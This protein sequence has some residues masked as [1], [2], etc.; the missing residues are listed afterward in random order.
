MKAHQ[1]ALASHALLS[2]AGPACEVPPPPPPHLNHGV[3]LASIARDGRQQV[4]RPAVNNMALHPAADDG[5]QPSG[6]GEDN[7]ESCAASS[8]VWPHYHPHSP[9]PHVKKPPMNAHSISDP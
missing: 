5:R 6:G 1:A 3:A 7:L 4:S 9:T 2:N 8:T